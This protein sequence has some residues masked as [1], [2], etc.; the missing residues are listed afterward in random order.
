MIVLYIIFAFALYRLIRNIILLRH[1][2]KLIKANESLTPFLRLN[3]PPEEDDLLDNNEEYTEEHLTA[4]QTEKERRT[5]FYKQQAVLDADF[6][7]EQID[8]L[9]RELRSVEENISG[10]E[11]RAADFEAVRKYDSAKKC[12]AVRDRLLKRR[13]TLL[14]QIHGMEKK[15]R[16]AQFKAGQKV[17]C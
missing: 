2:K 15:L 9:Y 4:P 1:M 10:Q 13:R 3:E 12:I 8:D 14:G 5:E 6:L 17:A 11:Q 7:I 16:T